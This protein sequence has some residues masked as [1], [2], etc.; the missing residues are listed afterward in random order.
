MVP[1]L[2]RTC[3]TLDPLAFVWLVLRSYQHRLDVAP[4]SYASYKPTTHRPKLPSPSHFPPPRPVPVA[5]S[6]RFFGTQRNAIVVHAKRSDAE[7]ENLTGRV[8]GPSSRVESVFMRRLTHHGIKHPMG[9]PTT[10]GFYR[11]IVPHLAPGA[12]A[13][14]FT[15][16]S[17]WSRCFF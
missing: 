1:N 13:F 6:N 11:R 14:V 10:M 9:I 5:G 4:P 17:R 7:F 15:G 8:F 12:S 3:W 16:L 2:H